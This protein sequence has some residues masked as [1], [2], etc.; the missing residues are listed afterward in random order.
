M[1][2]EEELSM[3]CL[4]LFAPPRL[5]CKP[6]IKEFPLRKDKT[7][8]LLTTGNEVLYFIEKGKIVNTYCFP[9]RITS[10]ELGI[11]SSNIQVVVVTEEGKIWSL[12]VARHKAKRPKEIDIHE[13]TSNQGIFSDLL[14]SSPP[15][16]NNG[17]ISTS[18]PVT[19]ISQ[20]Q[21]VIYEP[22]A[23]RAI[24]IEDKLVICGGHGTEYFYSVYTALENGHDS[25]CYQTQPLRRQTFYD[26]T[27]VNN[28]M[29]NDKL[30]SLAVLGMK[31]GDTRKADPCY[32][33]EKGL[34]TQLF[35][36]DAILTNANVLLVGLPSG[37]VMYQNIH[38]TIAKAP[39]LLFHLEQ[40]VV[41]IHC[42][43][44][45]TSLQGLRDGNKES[46]HHGNKESTSDHRS[47]SDKLQPEEFNAIVMV[48]SCGKLVICHRVGPGGSGNDFQE[49][50]LPGPVVCTWLYAN[51]LVH[52][53]GQDMFVTKLGLTQ[54]EGPHK[55]VES[56]CPVHLPIPWIST[57]CCVPSIH[58]SLWCYCLTNKGK[59]LEFNPPDLE[60]T[61]NIRVSPVVV[62]ERLKKVLTAIEKTVIDVN[63]KKEEITKSESILKELNTAATLACELH[64][65]GR[66]SPITWSVTLALNSANCGRLP[67][68]FLHCKITNNSCLTLTS[69]W[70]LLVT[71]K[72]SALWPNVGQNTTHSTPLGDFKARSSRELQL[73]FDSGIAPV[74]MVTIE[75]SMHFNV[76]QVLLESSIS[77]TVGGNDRSVLILL[78]VNRFTPEDFARLCKPREVVNNMTAV[79]E[80][81]QTLKELSRVVK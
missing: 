3:K 24:Q 49:Y 15:V 12:G 48:G 39:A 17:G 31:T 42:A 72:E 22:H 63:R 40:A 55:F 16:K 80:L 35:G 4:H 64:N 36:R 14:A 2:D 32:V 26:S 29:G 9:S 5:S 28:L 81:Q 27:C 21:A 69:N 61:H 20:S 30:L 53:T 68:V 59:L 8:L 71:I 76:K 7:G 47:T 50:N 6:K 73:P 38:C 13:G 67:Q 34:F 70:S 75:A 78:G 56:L 19:M 41:S 33:L 60:S 45:P 79:Q 54:P 43:C 46:Y 62:G 11:H 23:L 51:I 25:Q 44:L 1:A 57:L 18:I 77:R 74:S 66:R 58:G 52:S 10:F 65:P 37:Q